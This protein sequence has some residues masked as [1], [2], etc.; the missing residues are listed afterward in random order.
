MERQAPQ[1]DAPTR[2][3]TSWQ[4]KLHSQIVT[5][6][7]FLS[8]AISGMAWLKRKEL[9]QSPL[10]PSLLTGLM[11]FMAIFGILAFSRLPRAIIVPVHLAG[12][13]AMLILLTWMLLRQMPHIAQ[14][15]SGCA[16]R[17]SLFAGLGLLILV[18]QIMLGSWVSSNFAAIACTSFPL[19]EGSLLPVMDFSYPP[20][21]STLTQE[22]LIA[23]HLMHRY[24][25]ILIW[26]YLCWLALA[27]VKLGGMRKI[28]L[29]LLLLITLQFGLGIANVL[30]GMP[31]VGAVLH[32]ALAMILLVTLVVLNFKLKGGWT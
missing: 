10:L 17:W 25:A 3:Y 31:L 26:S 8:I 18:I 6:L 28:G 15:E 5:L 11:V 16:R 4:R 29:S 21:S 1:V 24:G 22:M 19:C 7:G 30:V 2:T 14:I 9:R 12:G 23:I 27:I 20:D 13:V 32:N